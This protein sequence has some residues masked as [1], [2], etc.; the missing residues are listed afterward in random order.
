MQYMDLGKA[1]VGGK[2]QSIQG[3]H[4]PLVFFVA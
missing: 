4:D 3:S 1:E 2:I